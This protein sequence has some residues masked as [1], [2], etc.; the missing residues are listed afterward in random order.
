MLAAITLFYAVEYWNE[1]FQA[2]IY[3]NNHRLYPLQ[4]V[5]REILFQSSGEEVLDIEITKASSAAVRM[6]TIV[7]TTVPVLLVYPFLQRYFTQGI[8]LGSVKE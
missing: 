8:L 6:A 2:I 4:V 5:L 1:F 3:I 7:V